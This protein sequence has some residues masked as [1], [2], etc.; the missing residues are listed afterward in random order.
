VIKEG[1][2]TTA[3]IFGAGAPVEAQEKP[4]PI[5]EQ[6]ERL[7]V[8]EMM[9]GLDKYI[10]FGAEPA[11]FREMQQKADSPDADKYFSRK[12]LSGGRGYE[13]RYNDEGL[14][15]N[16]EINKT[17]TDV[18]FKHEVTSTV[19]PSSQLNLYATTDTV[20]IV[21]GVDNNLKSER[22]VGQATPDAVV[23]R[24]FDNLP[25]GVEEIPVDL[26]GTGNLRYIGR[27]GTLDDK[28]T[29]FLLSVTDGQV[30]YQV[31][32]FEFINPD[33]QQPV[34]QTIQAELMMERVAFVEDQQEYRQKR[35]EEEE[36]ES[37]T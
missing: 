6:A 30:I 4:P 1:L 32:D 36:E 12:A 11:F 33:T 26:L 35:A 16:E 23:F 9:V 15:E 8:S 27:T 29:W 3:M 24:Y 21:M 13:Y 25:E 14:T 2:L 5:V 22:R 34:D 7:D 28:D 10:D 18:F 20:N 19:D 17:L 37:A 31:T